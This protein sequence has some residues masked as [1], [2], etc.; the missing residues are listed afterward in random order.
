MWSG[1]ASRL[2]LVLVA[3]SYLFGVNAVESMNTLG[4]N[5]LVEGLSSSR[6]TKL[7]SEKY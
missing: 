2:S 6:V 5:R 4:T 3:I 1:R 7:L